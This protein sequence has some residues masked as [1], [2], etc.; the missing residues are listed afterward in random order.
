MPALWNF[1]SRI[2]IGCLTRGAQVLGLL[3]LVAAAFRLALAIQYVTD[4][5]RMRDWEGAQATILDADYKELPDASGPQVFARYRYRYGDVDYEGS[6]VDVANN[7]EHFGDLQKRIAERLRRHVNDKSPAVV[8][9]NPGDPA[10][11][12]LDREFYPTVF[13]FRVGFFLILGVLG[14]LLVAGPT[15]VRRK[16]IE[17]AQLQQIHP[18]EPWMWRSDWAV[19]VIRSSRYRFARLAIWIF[20]LYLLVILPAALWIIRQRGN[21]IVSLAGIVVIGLAWGLFNL[22]RM[23]FKGAKMFRDAEFRMS[24]VPGLVGGPLAGVVV[25]KNRF[26]DDT[27][28]RVIV[29]CGKTDVVAVSSNDKR[30]DESI[31][32]RDQVTVERTL[33]M[34]DPGVTAIPVYVAIPFDCEPSAAST[35]HKVRWWLKIGPEAT[36]FDRYAQ[37]EVPVYKTANSSARFK[38]DPELM[39]PYEAPVDVPDLLSRVGRVSWLPDGTERLRFSYFDAMAACIGLVLIAACA[40]GVAALLYYGFHPAWTMMPAIFGFF[41]TL[42][43]LEMLLWGSA[44]DIGRNRITVSA[45]L[46]GIRR[47]RSIAR[48]QIS[49]CMEIETK[50]ELAMQAQDWYALQL[51]VTPMDDTDSGNTNVDPASIGEPT[52]HLRIVRRL[53]TRREADAVRDW[54]CTRLGLATERQQPTQPGD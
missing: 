31:P 2:P 37:F 21:D 24:S 36:A 46:A 7:P 10:E 27:K 39:Q 35:R 49:E 4:A 41:V 50:K 22:A 6:R 25:V 26:P 17:L 18:N 19:G 47:R 20:A 13:A 29:E 30:F 16:E 9:V 1:E 43:L 5:V 48:E 23:Q 15:H 45:G 34:P 33:S 11:S 44:I 3:L 38:P 14:G 12:V 32:W 42:G 52:L 8:Y 54:L 53:T 28:F 51:N 40:G